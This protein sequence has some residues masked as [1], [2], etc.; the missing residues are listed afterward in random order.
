MMATAVILQQKQMEA[1]LVNRSGIAG[2][3]LV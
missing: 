1:A 2:G 3:R